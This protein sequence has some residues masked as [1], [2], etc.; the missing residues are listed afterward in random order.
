MGPIAA[1]QAHAVLQNAERILAIELLVAGQALDLRAPL[2]PADG[3]RAALG[4]LRATVPHL[5]ADRLLA[6]DLEA[7]ARLVRDGDVLRATEQ[8]VGPLD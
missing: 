5:D 8:A 4:V 2:V 1:R 3:P 6:D 7:A